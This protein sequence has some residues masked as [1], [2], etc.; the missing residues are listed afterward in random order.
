MNESFMYSP[1]RIVPWTMAPEATASTNIATIE[2]T[3]FLSSMVLPF[4]VLVVFARPLPAQPA[5]HDDGD[6]RNQRREMHFDHDQP[7]HALALFIAHR[8]RRVVVERAPPAHEGERGL[9][10]HQRHREEEADL[11]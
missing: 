5:R 7:A 1:C 3:S 2:I 8:P 11:R 6:E 10:R 4:S 9:D